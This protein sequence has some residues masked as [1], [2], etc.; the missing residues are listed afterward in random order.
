MGDEVPAEGSGGA[1]ASGSAQL[2]RMNTG[3]ATLDVDALIMKLLSVRGESPV[4]IQ[5][6]AGQ[7]CTEYT[8]HIVLTYRRKGGIL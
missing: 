3:I 8:N 7:A 4:L 1:P 6:E 2:K 5:Y